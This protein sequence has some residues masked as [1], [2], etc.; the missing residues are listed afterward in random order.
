VIVNVIGYQLPSS[1]NI[2]PFLNEIISALQNSI[3]VEVFGTRWREIK[4]I[5]DSGFPIIF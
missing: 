4:K 3:E 2:M 1:G 5:Q